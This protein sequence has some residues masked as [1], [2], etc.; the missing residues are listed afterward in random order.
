MINECH[1]C[2]EWVVNSLGHNNEF[3]QFCQAECFLEFADEHRLQ[4]DTGE[5]QLGGFLLAVGMLALGARIGQTYLARPN[6]EAPRHIEEIRSLPPGRNRFAIE[7]QADGEFVG[8]ID[9]VVDGQTYRRSV[10]GVGCAR[11]EVAATTLSVWMRPTARHDSLR[12]EV[13]KNGEP[14]GTRTVKPF[15]GRVVIASL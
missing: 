9:A 10:E 6:V 2:G 8:S 4:V 3:G 12:I 1:Q 14:V 11:F 15:Q 7:V 13:M 5:E